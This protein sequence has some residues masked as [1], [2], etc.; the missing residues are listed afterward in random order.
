MTTIEPYLMSPSEVPSDQK[1]APVMHMMKKYRP[2]AEKY[3]S[4]TDCNG[5][6]QETRPSVVEEKLPSV[7]EYKVRDF[8]G[9]VEA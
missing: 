4:S 6:Q 5:G 8:K 3:M 1:S 2:P 7:P 9:R